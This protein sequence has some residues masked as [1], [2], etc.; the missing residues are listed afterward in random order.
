MVNCTNCNSEI[1]MERLEAIRD[2][3]L[4]YTCVNC[5]K[6]QSPAVFMSFEH[7]TG[8]SLFVV[9][10]NPDGTQNEERVRQARRCFN[11]ER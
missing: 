2:F 1:S 11:R 7:K 5:S 3:N 9:P 8:G 6:T 10:N 4:S